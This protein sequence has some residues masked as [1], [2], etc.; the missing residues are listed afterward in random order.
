MQQQNKFFLLKKLS[1][2]GGI[3]ASSTN[4]FFNISTVLLDKFKIFSLK[5]IPFE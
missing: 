4:I 3:G 2:I 1:K 5:K